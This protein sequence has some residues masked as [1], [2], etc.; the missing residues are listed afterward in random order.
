MKGFWLVLLSLVLLTTFSTSAFAIDVKF[1][2]EFYVAGLYLDK[3]NLR[4][5]SGTDGISTAF[6][7]QRLRVRTD[8]VVSPG[9][10]LITR[11]DAM[12]RVW[13]AARST[14]GTTN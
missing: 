7:Y 8:F 10:T 3:T 14:P 12:D 6:C 1:S 11:F 9:L 4:E 2:G 13:G 5:N